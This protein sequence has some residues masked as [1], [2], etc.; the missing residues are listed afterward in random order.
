MHSKS[1]KK[2]IMISDVT[3]EII[4][5]LFNSLKKRYQ[6]NLQSMR[7]SEFVLYLYYKS[8]Y[9]KYHKINLNCGG[10]HRFS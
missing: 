9:H 2:E 1:D 8:M 6:N 4:E 7:R 10:S 3:D 5:N